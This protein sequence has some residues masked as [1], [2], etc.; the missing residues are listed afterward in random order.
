MSSP[1]PAGTPA[2]L[3]LASDRTDYLAG[4]LADD[5]PTDPLA[6]L[7]HWLADAFARR[8]AEGDLPDPTAAVLSTVDLTG[9]VPRPRSRTV[10]L[11]G[12]GESGFVFYTNRDSDKGAEIAGDAQVALVLP[13][14]ALQR[15]V[16][17]EGR[18][19]LVP[20]ADSDAYWASRPRASQLGGWASQQ[21]RP[22]ASREQLEAQF[23]EVEARFEDEADVPRPPHWGGY[24]VIPDRIEFWQGR[25]GRVHDRLVYTRDAGGTWSRG[26]LQP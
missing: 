24:R 3:D 23:A 12:Q 4:S 9:P 15:Q 26:R 13:W 17:V 19:E 14:F 25:G 2:P 10:L 8:E 21:S 18:A 5:A 6:L 22:V 1:S 16:R 20:D 11:K 7:E